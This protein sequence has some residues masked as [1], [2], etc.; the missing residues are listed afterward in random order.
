MQ[1]TVRRLVL[2]PEHKAHDDA[3]VLDAHRLQPD[4]PR[5]LI[6]AAPI[7]LRDVDICSQ[8]AH[9]NSCSQR[10]AHGAPYAHYGKSRLAPFSRFQF[11][12]R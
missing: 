12:K 4:Q 6:A 7:E 10:G 1:I 2:G 8:L 9:T 5:E 3:I 11:F